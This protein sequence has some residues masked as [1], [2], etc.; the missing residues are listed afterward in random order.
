VQAEHAE[1]EA[2]G[3]LV[4]NDNPLMLP[5]ST[6]VMQAARQ[7]ESYVVSAVLVIEGEGNLVGIF[8]IRDALSRVIAKGMDPVT[9]PL[10]EV[11]T[12]Q[13]VTMTPLNTAMEALRLMQGAHCRHLPIVHNGKI[14]GLIS[15]GNFRTAKQEPLDA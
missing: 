9:T 6:T 10:A 5:P 2:E 4:R 1:G 15:R 3:E 8:T 13:P 7:M 14:I 11:M 12:Y